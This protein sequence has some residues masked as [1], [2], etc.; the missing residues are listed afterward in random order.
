MAVVTKTKSSAF[1]TPEDIQKLREMSTTSP[2]AKLVLSAFEVCRACGGTGL[3]FPG[4]PRSEKCEECD[5][6]GKRRAR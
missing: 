2:L 3:E 1:G 4:N 5:G 6:D